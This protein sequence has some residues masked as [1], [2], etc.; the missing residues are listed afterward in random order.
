MAKTKKVPDNPVQ[1]PAHLGEADE[2]LRLIQELELENEQNRLQLA[3]EIAAIT[4]PYLRGFERNTELIERYMEG[5]YRYAQANKETL[6]ESGKTKTVQLPSGA[7][8]WRTTPPKVSIKDEDAVLAE[9][10]RRHL[11]QF[12]R[13]TPEINKDKMLKNPTLA[14]S[15]TGV[16]ITQTEEFVIK[17]HQIL[18][19]VTA[20][21][22]KTNKI[23]V[24]VIDLHPKKKG[25]PKKKAS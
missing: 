4:E 14:G 3:A 1:V 18:A 9:L 21:A 20:S 22:T 19:E 11:E 10:Q 23:K 7:L 6:T 15:V 16:S 24:S 13:R 8:L 17:P 25:V 12:I 2:F 5:L